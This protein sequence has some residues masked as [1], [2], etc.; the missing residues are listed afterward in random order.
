MLLPFNCPYL[1]L[2]ESTSQHLMQQIFRDLGWKPHTTQV[3]VRRVC[4]HLMPIMQWF[5]KTKTDA[6]FIPFLFDSIYWV[7]SNFFDVPSVVRTSHVV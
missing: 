7:Y 1:V 3:H 2:S 5:C 4:L 6:P